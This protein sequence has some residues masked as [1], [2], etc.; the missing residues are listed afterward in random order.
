MIRY[1]TSW[2][3]EKNEERRAELI[4][5]IKKCCDS[6]D[7]DK[8]Y[9]V[10]EAAA[11]FMHEKMIE[12]PSATRYSFADFF[13]IMNAVSGE[14]D[15]CILANTDIFPAE[16]I[17]PLLELLQP[18]QAWCLSRWDTVHG[19]PEP[20]HFN[21]PDSQDV[22]CVRHPIKKIEANFLIGWC[23]SDNKICYQLQEAGYEVSNPS[24]D[25]KF[26]HYHL[27]GLHNYDPAKHTVPSPYLLIHPSHLND[28]VDTRILSV[29]P[30]VY[31]PITPQMR[32][33]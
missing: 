17:R 18:N 16:N 29:Q 27:T 2:Y 24:K 31:N 10:C 12:V 28:R 4:T 14:N 20:V 23:G 19:R 13:L 25:V 21:R 22:F 26:I 15:L 7:I 30:T 3:V 6:P 5:C 33:E 9:L 11:P 1:F 32:G 8:V